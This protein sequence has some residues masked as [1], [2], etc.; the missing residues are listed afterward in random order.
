MLSK[1]RDPTRQD[2][3]NKKQ[4]KQ[5]KKTYTVLKLLNSHYQSVLE[6]GKGWHTLPLPHPLPIAIDQIPFWIGMSHYHM[7]WAGLLFE[8]KLSYPRHSK[9]IQKKSLRGF[10]VLSE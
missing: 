2:S 7:I 3:R 9:G 5:M 6:V 10:N 4:I 1:N 8:N